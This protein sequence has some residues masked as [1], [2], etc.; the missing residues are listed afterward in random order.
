MISKNIVKYGLGGGVLEIVYVTL[1]AWFM[2]N[3]EKFIS[4]PD[5]AVNIIFVLLL[6]VFSVTVS[7]LLIFGYPVY[8]V[9]QKNYKQ[10]VDTVLVSLLTLVIGGLIIFNILIF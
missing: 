2:Q 5:S 10:A 3:V 9:I 4:G 8:L 1:I 7:G 6:L